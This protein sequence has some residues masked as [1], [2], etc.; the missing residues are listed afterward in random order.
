MSVTKAIVYGTLRPG[1]PERVIRVKAKMFDLGWF[2]GIR[3]GGNEEIIG[4]VIEVTDDSMLA[5][6]DRYE[7][8]CEEDPQA[9]LYIR[10]QVVID[11]QAYWIYEYN[12]EPDESRL[13]ESGNWL[14]FTN[15]ERGLNA[16]LAVPALEKE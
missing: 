16:H 3:L 4:E 12:D 9:S 8:Y 7:G 6:L 5:S 14:D 13:I 15:E 10:R 11:G 1:E 2:P